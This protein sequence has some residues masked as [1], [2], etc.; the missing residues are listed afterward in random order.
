MEKGYLERKEVCEYLGISKTTFFREFARELPA[1][2]VGRRLKYKRE[3][4]DKFIKKV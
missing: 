2:R 4:V 1:Y 3:D